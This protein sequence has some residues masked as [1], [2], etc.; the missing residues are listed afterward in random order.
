MIIGLMVFLTLF[1]VWAVW[2]MAYRRRPEKTMKEV[3]VDAVMA[4]EKSTVFSSKANTQNVVRSKFFPDVLYVG[5]TSKLDPTLRV[6][7]PNVLFGF[8]VDPLIVSGF[9]YFKVDDN[10]FEEVIFEKLGDKNY[11]MLYDKHEN[12]IYFLNRL[13]SQVIGKNETPPMASQDII[14]LEENATIYYYNDFSG[15]IETQVE[16]NG[17]LRNQYRL[18]RVYEREVTPDDNEYLIC[19]MDKTDVIDYYIGFNISIHQ[20]EEV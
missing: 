18:I 7:F 19:M 9:R 14:S 11:I 3:F 16:E 15:L 1:I 2:F 13:M 4:P 10:P 6:M 5:K 12:Q 17:R 8:P 20:L